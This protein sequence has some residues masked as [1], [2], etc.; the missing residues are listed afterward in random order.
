MTMDDERIR[1]LTEEVL[2]Q[3]RAPGGSEIEER[4]AALEAQVKELSA[5]RTGSPPA[6]AAAVVEIHTHHHDP[7]AL[8]VLDVGGGADRCV[9]EPDKPCAASGMCRALGH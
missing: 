9:M 7:P 2:S 8:R 4:L 5:G 1:Q 3:I 6:V